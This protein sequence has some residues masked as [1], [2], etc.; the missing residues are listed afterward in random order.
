[1][2]RATGTRLAET[3]IA[4]SRILLLYASHYGQTAAIAGRIRDRL[5]ERGHDVDMF[6]VEV[7]VPPPDRYDAVVLGSRIE[8]GKHAKQIAQ[9][10]QAHRDVLRHT[11]TAFFSV[12]M[13][14]AGKHS[15]SDP[16]RYLATTFA[17]LAWTPTV[18][19]AFGGALQYRRYNWLLRMVMKVISKQGGHSTDTSKN[20]FYTDFSDVSDFADRFAWHLGER[21]SVAHA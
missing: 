6:N 13:S 9:Y 10:V 15:G 12:S 14:A 3:T 20:H 18:S 19:T 21:E 11:P 5:L 17:D 8:F 1:M 4:M 2:N 16:N 7:P